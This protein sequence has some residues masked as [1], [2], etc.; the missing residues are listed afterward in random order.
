MFPRSSI[1]K[2]PLRLA[3]SIGLIDSGYT[4]E[5]KAAFH[6]T[7]KSPFTLRKG[8]RY[9]QLVRSDLGPI[10]MEVVDTIRSTSRDSGFGSTL[11]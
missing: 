8:D 7:G 6:N 9:V 4:G 3:N 11:V 2:S 1:S 5:L 10:N